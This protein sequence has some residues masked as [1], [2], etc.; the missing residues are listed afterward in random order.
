M[1]YT[2]HKDIHIFLNYFLLNY[3]T[4][5]HSKRRLFPLLLDQ[6]LWYLGSYSVSQVSSHLLKLQCAHDNIVNSDL[7]K[8]KLERTLPLHVL[9]C[10]KF[11]KE[12]LVLW[13]DKVFPMNM[14]FTL[15][16]LMTKNKFEYIL[17][18]FSGFW[19]SIVS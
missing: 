9:L 18:G 1:D 17:C 5:Q 12:S 13:L 10:I 4:L 14:Q 7:T 11:L 6:F 2:N 19:D 16:P 3:C 15:Y 8:L